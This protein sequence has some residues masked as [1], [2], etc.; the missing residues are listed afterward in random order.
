MDYRNLR[1]SINVISLHLFQ[2]DDGCLG[3]ILKCGDKDY[4]D[5]DDYDH[6]SGG[7]GCDG[8]GLVV[9]LAMVVSENFRSFV[10][11]SMCLITVVGKTLCFYCIH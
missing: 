11:P 3:S 2:A 9:V 10:P 5:H 1:N 8:G 7:G 4:Y 6:G